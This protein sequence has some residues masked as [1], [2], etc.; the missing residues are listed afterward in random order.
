MVTGFKKNGK[1]IPTVNK[2]SS[3]VSKTTLRKKQTVGV[4]EVNSLLR[5]KQTNELKDK[6]TDGNLDHIGYNVKLKKKEKIQNAKHVMTK[7][8]R[9]AIKGVGSDGTIMYKFIKAP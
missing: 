3:S 9:H 2:K 1:F 7:N 5:T 4:N 6:K 8:G